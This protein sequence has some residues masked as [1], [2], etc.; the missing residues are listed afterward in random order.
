MYGDLLWPALDL[1]LSLVSNIY[2]ISILPYILEVFRARF[3]KMLGG[4][5]AIIGRRCSNASLTNFYRRNR[6][7]HGTMARR[8]RQS[9]CTHRCKSAAARGARRARQPRLRHVRFYEPGSGVSFGP[10]LIIL[11]SLRLVTWKPWFWP[12]T[13][14]RPDTWLHLENSGGALGLSHR[15][16][17]K[18]CRSPLCGHSLESYDMGVF[19]APQQVAGGKIP[20]GQQ[21]LG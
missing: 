12:L 15:E 2:S 20:Q 5:P 9:G 21:L 14:P 11:R 18:M 17:S 1:E 19:N 3:I 4:L 8:R 16:L 13:W 6:A 7:G 10:K